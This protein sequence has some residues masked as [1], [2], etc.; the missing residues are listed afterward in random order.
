MLQMKSFLFIVALIALTNFCFSSKLK[1][2]TGADYRVK[3]P[4]GAVIDENGSYFLCLEE[5]N[6]SAYKNPTRKPWGAT[7]TD[8]K[9]TFTRL[10]F[11]PWT[12]K[13]HTGDYTYADSTGYLGHHKTDKVP[14]G[15]AFGCE[16][17]HNADGESVIDLRGT[18]YAVD[19]TFRNSGYLSAGSAVVSENGQKVVLR[20]GGYCGWFAA[21]SGNVGFQGTW[22]SFLELLPEY[23]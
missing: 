4:T 11:N 5:D 17:P 21:V 18:P 15:T 7:D 10:R 23:H 6:Y 14:L 9:T 2:K 22:A 13:V 1:S 16:A 8:V 20:G 19:D 3:P 12:L